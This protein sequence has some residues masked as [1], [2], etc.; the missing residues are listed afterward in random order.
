MQKELEFNDSCTAL[1]TNVDQQKN[2][3]SDLTYEIHDLIQQS[4][5][6]I[7][8]IAKLTALVAKWE[9]DYKSTKEVLE[10]KISEQT[11]TI[12]DFTRDRALLVQENK[13]HFL[14]YLTGKIWKQ[15]QN[16]KQ[17]YQNSK[18]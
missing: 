17:I 6:Q 13:Y 16:T 11:T 14:N 10:E 3:I 18:I 7:K 12:A 2:S 9:K 15:S 8:E 1:E 4:D 5:K